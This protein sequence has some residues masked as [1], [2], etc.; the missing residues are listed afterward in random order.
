MQR[1]RAIIHRW[2]IPEIIHYPDG[3]IAALNGLDDNGYPEYLITYNN[4]RAAATTNTTALWQGGSLGLNLKGDSEFIINRLGIWEA[5]GNVLATHEELVG[6]ITFGD[7]DRSPSAHATHVAGTMIAAGINPIAR[8]MAF[9]AKLRSYSSTNDIA[10][11]TTASAAGMIIS[12]HS[13]GTIS[14]WNNNTSRSGTPDNPRWEW[15]GDPTVSGVEDWKFGFYDTRARDI[16]RLVFNAPYY[17]PVFAAGNSRTQ[18]GP[19]VGQP[20][21]QRDPAA[22]GG[23]RLIEARPDSIS[24]NNS[25]NTIPTAGNAKNILTIGAVNPIPNGYTRPADVVMSAFSSWGPTDDGRIKPDLV[26]N[27]VAV[28]SATNTANNAYASMQGTSM[29]TPNISGTLFL[30]QELYG[31]QNR[32]NFMLAATLKALAIHTANEAGEHPGPDYR[33]GWGLLNAEEAGRA[34]LNRDGTYA[35][36]EERLEQGQTFTLQVIASGNGPLKATIAWTDPE[37]TSLPVIRANL[38]NRSP[39]L[40][41]D[42]DLRI[43]EGSIV[44]QPWILDPDRPEAPAARGDNFRDNVEQVVIDNPVPGKTYTIRVSHKGTLR[45]NAQNFSLILSGVGGTAYCHSAPSSNADS[46]IESVNFANLN[47][48]PE[49]ACRAYADFTDL[50][51]Q[52]AP[53]QQATLSINVGT[54]GADFPKIARVFID[55]NGNGNFSDTG[56]LVATSGVITG[57]QTF[58]T[59]INVPTTVQIGRFTRMRIVLVETTN[60]ASI[61]SCG[62]YAKGETRDYRVAFVRPQ[63][64]IAVT[65]LLSPT[66]G[67]CPA[68]PLNAIAIG[69]RNAGTNAITNGNFSLSITD[70][71]NR[72]I[73][74]TTGT[75]SFSTG[76]P[77]LAS[78]FVRINL[79]Q[80]ISL[81]AAT[82]YTFRATFTVPNDSN[83]DNNST[84]A[85]VRT[86]DAPVA[87]TGLSAVACGTSGPV[88]LSRNSDQLGLYWYDA[89]SGGNLVGAGNQAVTNVRPA[90]GRYYAGIND[91]FQ[92]GLGPRNKET[93]ASG[94]YNQ[95]SPFITVRVQQPVIIESARLYIGNSGQI[96]FT[97]TN[98]RTREEVS[99]VLLNV[100][101]TRTIPGAGAQENDPLDTGQ[102][103]RLDLAFPQPGDYEISIAYG[104]GA[105]IFRNNNIPESQ[106]PYPLQIPGVITFTGNSATPNPNTFWYYFYDITLRALGCPAPRAEV[107]I[108]QVGAPSV[109]VSTSRS[110]PICQ[111]ESVTLT[112]TSSD[113]N[114]G[115]QWQR[116]GVNITN[117][118]FPTLTV[119]EEGEFRVVVTNA[120]GCTVTSTPVRVN[121]ISVSRPVVSVQGQVFTSSYPTGNQWLLNG[122]PIPG[123]T[124]QTYNADQAGVY[125]VQVT[126]NGCTA[127]SDPIVLTS[128]D[129][130]LSTTGIKLYPNPA[131]ATL[132]VLLRQ[133]GNT[134]VQMRII[135]PTG[136]VLQSVAS[137]KRA[138]ALEQEFDVRGLA[139]GIYFLQIHTAEGIAIQPFVKE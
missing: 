79:S 14:G 76:L 4:T 82:N 136:R 40:V 27:G 51:V 42:L 94:N 44:H 91:F 60:P 3:T 32:G 71:Q 69:V 10:E 129:E 66:S 106:N 126:V 77:S 90:S 114:V 125:A 15:H 46:R 50:T 17:L 84:I 41:N 5:G 57:S 123:A 133:R 137:E 100:R 72:T 74:N 102:V 118:N 81:E 127:V 130:A 56:E 135:D 80:P 83:P 75:F 78:S 97:V 98:A 34:I 128:T 103:Y 43:L 53:G 24:S 64:D 122:N 28:V 49:N 132:K 116:N 13:Y 63:A 95:F 67:T 6:R 18:T 89:P 59:T 73:L 19:A 26:G 47:H 1:A 23:F 113:I 139:K 70:P 2:G 21:W 45:G 101:A 9:G 25:W 110:L 20:Y 8:G 31:Q 99:S 7:E 104:G 138:L 117:A 52:L 12:N 65:G 115:Y 131:D 38:N 107:A 92:R 96:Q 87:P 88:T 68:Q 16:D 105:T 39:R 54:C 108:T 134:P 111:G 29:A 121:V 37:G 58:T 11:M 124:G 109:Q 85:V 93:F 62:S 119:A 55:W 30:L 120:N 33:F 112:A 35:I 48:S 61:A 86:A 22:Q 36:R